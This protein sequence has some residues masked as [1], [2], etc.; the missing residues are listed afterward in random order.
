MTT[1]TLEI[2]SLSKNAIEMQ[3]L[4]KFLLTDT[5][6]S[7]KSRTPR[8]YPQEQ[9]QT[10]ATEGAKTTTQLNVMRKERHNWTYN[11][12][13]TYEADFLQCMTINW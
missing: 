13:Q 7:G 9:E 12:L 11:C 6:N 5:T 10:N 8:P 1:F 3:I 4:Q 2:Y